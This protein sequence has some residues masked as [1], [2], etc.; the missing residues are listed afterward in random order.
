MVT[1]TMA[2][3]VIPKVVFPGLS[4][5]G[6]GEFGAIWVWMLGEAAAAKLVQKKTMIKKT[7]T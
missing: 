2:P 3:M 4:S 6:T 7:N 1:N 5:P